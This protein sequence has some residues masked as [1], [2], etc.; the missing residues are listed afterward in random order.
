VAKGS[1]KYA[2]HEYSFTSPAK[3]GL[4]S[5]LG[6]HKSEASSSRQGSRTYPHK[7]YDGG[8]VTPTTA[9]P[10]TTTGS[11]VGGRKLD[12]GGYTPNTNTGANLS[13]TAGNFF[14]K[15]AGHAHGG[16]VKAQ[17]KSQKAEHK[18]NNKKDDKVPILATE[19]EIVLPKSVTKAKDAPE[20]AEKFVEKEKKKK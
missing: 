19:G 20:K 2:G 16:E 9:Q 14:G 7:M 13:S 18:G 12:K 17:N 11:D 10:T 5:Q 1:K 3:S 6:K 15:M 4:G 8:T